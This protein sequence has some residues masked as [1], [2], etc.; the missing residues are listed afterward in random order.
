MKNRHSGRTPESRPPYVRA[1]P[2]AWTPAS[3]GATKG[4]AVIPAA[5]RN[6]DP[7]L[8]AWLEPGPQLPL[9]RRRKTGRRKGNRHSRR[10]PESRPRL[11][12]AAAAW[13][14]ASAGATHEHSSFRPHAGIQAPSR[15][16]LVQVPPLGVRLLDQLQLPAPLPGLDRLFT[17]DR[18]LHGFVGLVPDQRVHP[19][20]F[21]EPVDKVFLVP[22]DA[23]GEVG[24]DARVERAVAAAGQQCRRRAASFTQARGWIPA[25]AGMTVR[26]HVGLAR[27]G[28]R[29]G[30]QA[31]ALRMDCSRRAMPPD[32]T[33]GDGMSGV[34]IGLLGATRVAPPARRRGP[35]SGR[36]HPSSVP[37]GGKG[38]FMAPPTARS[39]VVVGPR[40]LTLALSQ[41][42]R[43]PPHPS[44]SS[45]RLK[46][47]SEDIMEK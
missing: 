8:R 24:G 9:G 3:A 21:G 5:R 37:M 13:A 17:P 41:R 23:L 46:S 33:T 18:R 34:S 47:M 39:A 12:G 10:T 28:G 43:G 14:P 35:A 19:V 15:Q 31:P 6:P 16:L 29:G 25:C 1:R 2:G 22:P 45:G 26:P 44:Y 4:K 40:A 27:N 36:P 42:E 30:G 32:A 11:A 38:C 20:S 7:V